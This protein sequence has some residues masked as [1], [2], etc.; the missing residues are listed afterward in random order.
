MPQ[1]KLSTVLKHGEP[2]LCDY[3]ASYIGFVWWPLSGRPED[4]QIV[5]QE[6]IEKGGQSE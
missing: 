6:C 5:C 1:E 4:L 2:M 3:C